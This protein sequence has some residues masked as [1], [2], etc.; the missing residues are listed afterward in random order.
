MKAGKII[1]VYLV[2]I[3]WLMVVLGG[4]VLFFWFVFVDSSKV[5]CR[6]ASF[7]CLFFGKYIIA[8]V[9]LSFFSIAAI[10]L[11]KCEKCK[12]RI[13]YNKEMDEFNEFQKRQN[14]PQF[15][16]WIDWFLKYFFNGRFRCWKCGYRL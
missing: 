7:I 5:D 2:L 4:G 16:F 9:G 10:P 3:G 15:N 8:L 1:S 14:L 11:V 13:L 6:S 12:C